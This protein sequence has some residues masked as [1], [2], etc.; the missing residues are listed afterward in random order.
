MTNYLVKAE[1]SDKAEKREKNLLYRVIT[2]DVT[3]FDYKYYWVNLFQDYL[4]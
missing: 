1:I 3:D 4:N 2:N